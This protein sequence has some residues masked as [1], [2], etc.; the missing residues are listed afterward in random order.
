MRRVLITNDDGFDSPGIRAL[1][2]AFARKVEV[3]LVA[4]RD[5]RSCSS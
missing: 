4:P 2:R 5:E 3:V 1:L